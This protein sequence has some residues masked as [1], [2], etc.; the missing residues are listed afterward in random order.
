MALLS[1]DKIVFKTKTVATDKKKH[2]I[3]IKV[4]VHQEH[5]KILHFYMFIHIMFL[6]VYVPNNIELKSTWKAKWTKQRENRK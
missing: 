3:M 4:A 6:N 2:F 5:I 1:S